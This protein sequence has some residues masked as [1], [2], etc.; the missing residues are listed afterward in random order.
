MLP[1]SQ[2]EF[3]LD[4]LAGYR[5]EADQWRQ[6]RQIR[7]EAGQVGAISRWIG[8][9]LIRLGRRLAPAPADTRAV[10]C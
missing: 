3:G 7:S 2:L 1:I 4:R 10:I 8:Q 9:L 5:Q 6:A